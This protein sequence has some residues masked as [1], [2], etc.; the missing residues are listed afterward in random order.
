MRFPFFNRKQELA[1]NERK[2]RFQQ[3]MELARDVASID[4]IGLQTLVRLVAAPLQAK[5]ITSASHAAPHC[6]RGADDFSCL[7]FWDSLPVTPDGRQAYKISSRNSD[8]HF[9]LRL[10]VDPVLA[11]P[12]HRDR[13]ANAIATIGFGKRQGSWSEDENHRV[14]IVLPMGVGIVFGGNHSM[15]A[16]IANGE[17][18]VTSTEVQDLTP[19]YAYV[20]Y[21][22]LSFLRIH[23]GA[24]LSQPEDEEPGMLF[25]IGRLMV[26]HGVIA[27]VERIDPDAAPNP[28]LSGGDGYYKVLING[29][30][31]GIALTS[32]GAALAL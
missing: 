25:E 7:F 19:L 23:D 12:W 27:A 21:D 20:Q 3:V 30:D 26:E 6:A 5:T 10:G 22:G 4:P 14:L 31:A 28:S 18:F 9:K 24:Q 1:R 8:Q 29:Q 13:L 16:G 17:G 32:S 2:A 15:A 11:T